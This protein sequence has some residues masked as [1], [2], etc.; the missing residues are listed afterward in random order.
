MEDIT[1][2][3][4]LKYNLNMGPGYEGFSGL[5]E[6]INL[7]DAELEKI[8]KWQEDRYTRIRVYDTESLEA[9]ITCWPAGSQGPIHNYELQQGWI[10]V[11]KGELYLEYY[12]L[13]STDIEAYGKKEIKEGE[14]AYLN[15]GLGYHRFAN[16]GDKPAIALHLYSDKITEWHKYNELTGLVELVPVTCD[17]EL[18]LPA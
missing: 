12:R 17:L 16:R 13:F 2:L 4:R 6:S 15:D 3:E 11:L 8:C 14:Y 1:T 18:D 9:V 10:K 7:T 5:I